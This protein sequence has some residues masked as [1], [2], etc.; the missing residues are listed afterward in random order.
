M[1]QQL[2][3]QL[4]PRMEENLRFPRGFETTG[5]PYVIFPIFNLDHWKKRKTRGYPAR[6]RRP[7]C[8]ELRN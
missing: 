6:V 8:H 3:K 5:N 1:N 2:P 7:D 4:Q